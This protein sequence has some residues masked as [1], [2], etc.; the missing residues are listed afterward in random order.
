[1]E[2][3]SS[4][5]SELVAAMGDA[6]AYVR[7]ALDLTDADWTLRT[8]HAVVGAQPVL[9]KRARW[10]YQRFM[11]VADGMAAS[12]LLRAFSPEGGQSLMIGEVEATVEACA[13]QAS[14]RRKPSHAPYDAPSLPWPTLDYDI[15]RRAAPPPGS[16]S[17]FQIGDDCPSFPDEQSA[18]RAFFHG[19]Y[20]SLSRSAVGSYELASIRLVRL[21]A[22]ID[23]VEVSPT[24]L[25]VH[26]LGGDRA[27]TR[28]EL[29]GSGLQADRTVGR[30]GRVRLALPDGLPDDAWLYLSRNRQWLD[31]RA[32][33]PRLSGSQDQATDERVLPDDPESRVLALLAQGEGPRVEFKRQLPGDTNDLRRKVL[34]TVAAFANGTGGDIVF[35]IDPD[36]LTLL[37]IDNAD[38]TSVRDKLGNVIRRRV[39]PTP[40]FEVQV[41]TVDHKMMLVLSISAGP[42]APYGLQFELDQQVEYY[43]RRGA[44]S[45]AATQAEVR[46]SVLSKI[47]RP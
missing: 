2:Y 33:G 32:L 40:E 5:L 16:L 46:E 17:A 29:N 1:M 37:G 28:V 42:S 34:K 13:E 35:G 41:V 27:G 18:M 10:Q 26:V 12:E 36:E 9:W 11:L 20:S 15:S 23:R 24:W 43:V 38:E 47:A 19:D 22:W 3:G 30:S 39:V 6:Q 14:W 45:Y 4:P 7:A 21:E 31:Y 44:S 25:Q 8:I